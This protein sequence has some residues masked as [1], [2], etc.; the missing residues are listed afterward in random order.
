MADADSAG[1]RLSLTGN[2]EDLPLLDILQIVSFS[3]KTGWLSIR[4][5][6]GEGAIVFDDGFVVAAFTWEAPPL[7]PRAAAL[8]VERRQE[9]VRGRIEMALERLVRLREGEFSFSLTESR[10]T[11][12]AGR[13]V[14]AEALAGGINPQE[15]LLDLA[16]GMDEDRRDS[17]AA[18]EMSFTE[19]PDVPAPAADGQ[20]EFDEEFAG[21]EPIA[22][23]TP[24]AVAAATEPE[25][26]STSEPVATSPEAAAPPA[27]AATPAP[28]PAAAPP[29]APEPA[30]SENPAIL[31]VD[32][33]AE[34]RGVLAQHLTEGGHQVLE[35]EDPESAVRKGHRLGKAGI[36]FVVL[37][38]LGMPASGGSS[39]QGGFEVVKRLGK[40][41]LSPPVIL[42]SE[43]F[44]PALQARARQMGIA[45]VVFKPGLSKLDPQQFRADLRAFA[46]KL[47]GEL[48]PAV[49]AAA[50]APPREKPTVRAASAEPPPRPSAPDDVARELAVLRERL[51][52]LREPGDAS[53]IAAMV[54]QVSREFF[55]RGVLFVVKNEE[56]RGV[57]AFGRG[58]G[59]ENLHLLAREIVFPLSEPS[60]LRQVVET[61]RSFLGPLPDGRWA[62]SLLGRIGRYKSNGAALLPLVTNRETVAVLYGDNPESGRG[63]ERLESLEVFV[64]QAGIALENAF[65]QR[66]VKALQSREVR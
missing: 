23:T 63:A 45:R 18:V 36:R 40:M 4:T 3:K 11:L 61:G 66:K 32:D 65:L 42:M 16:R 13:D 14:A 46:G 6:A 55:E 22:V 39:F 2:L 62:Q 5:Q 53:R 1:G 26:A 43:R 57:A 52:A 49:V 33:E 56:A 24:P 47:A 15:L 41:H 27:P 44:T 60:T 28:A 50:A 37:C 20:A 34:V 7:D 31:L 10:P 8:P 51:A 58:P 19:P 12:V 9:L 35:A 64:T 25:P 54:L 48:I 59:E 30:A 29:A 21:G 17:A 38:D